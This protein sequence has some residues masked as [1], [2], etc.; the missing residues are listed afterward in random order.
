MAKNTKNTP[1][2]NAPATAEKG[3]EQ[4]PYSQEEAI[5]AGWK[6]GEKNPSFANKFTI[7][8]SGDIKQFNAEGKQ[9]W[10]GK[11]G[12]GEGEQNNSS[13][14]KGG[15]MRLARLAKGDF[16]IYPLTGEKETDP[17]FIQRKALVEK[18]RLAIKA[19]APLIRVKT[20]DSPATSIIRPLNEVEIKARL[21]AI[22]EAAREY[23]SPL[24]KYETVKEEIPAKKGETVFLSDL[25]GA[26]ILADKEESGAVQAVIDCVKAA[27][28]AV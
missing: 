6:R 13:G 4:N 23:V 14:N 5:A 1:A 8:K 24:L 26:E 3:S 12:V 15:A 25:T 9:S 16:T 22:P 19:V 2:K 11:Y 27:L 17:D 20:L 18:G 7:L 21:D 28:R 10:P